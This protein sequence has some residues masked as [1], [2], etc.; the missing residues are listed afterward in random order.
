MEAKLGYL[1]QLIPALEPSC[2]HEIPNLNSD[3]VI[4]IVM[5]WSTK[6]TQM[7]NAAVVEIPQDI[8]ISSHLH[9]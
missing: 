4:Q 3:H 1:H 7:T 8:T 6:D 5:I 9:S 2:W